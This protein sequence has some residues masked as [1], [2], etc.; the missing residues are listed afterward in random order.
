MHQQK[1][2]GNLGQQAVGLGR[3]P[4]SE[5]FLLSGYARNDMLKTD[6]EQGTSSSEG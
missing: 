6:K 3:D 5:F 4:C 2:V 1:V